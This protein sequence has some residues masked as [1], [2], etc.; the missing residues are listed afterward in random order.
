MDKVRVGVS[1]TLTGKYSLQGIESFNGLVLWKENTNK[2]GGIKLKNSSSKIPVELIYYDDKSDPE[3]TSEITRKL[4]LEDKVDLLLGP[5]SSSLTLAAAKTSESLNRVLWNYGGS[6]DEITKSG[7]KKVVT[8]ITPASRY[9]EPFINFIHNQDNNLKKVALVF[10]KDSGFATEVAKG[11]MSV[12]DS[13]G[14]EYHTYT[15]NSGNEDFSDIINLINNEKIKYL[16]GVGRYEDDVNLAK[17]TKNL[18]SCLLAA[19][20]AEFYKQL[21]KESDGFFSVTQWEP[22]TKFNVDFG[23]SSKYFTD[24]YLEKY[25]KIPDYVAAQSF[26]MGVILEKFIG[27]SGSFDQEYLL[28][29]ITDAKF[30]TFYGNFELEKSTGFQS[31]HKTLVTQWQNGKKEIIYP[32]EQQTSEITLI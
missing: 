9:F 10:A 30:C 19:S 20:I 21:K 25:K 7:F 11:A 24:L 31:G 4:V 15:F 26:N 1:A 18:C 6:T 32:F 16:L 29:K 23:V 8:T 5:Y 13:L 14:I 12:C 27:E 22:N 17:H 2:S 28:K 3:N